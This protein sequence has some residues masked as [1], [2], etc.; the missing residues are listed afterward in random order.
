MSLGDA[1]IA[2]TAPIHDL[3]L[4]TRDADDFEHITGRRIENPFE[5][6]DSGQNVNR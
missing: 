6:T 3:P 5:P 1:I 4:V 2:A